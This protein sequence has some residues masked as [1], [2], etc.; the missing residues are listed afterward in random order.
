MFRAIQNHKL[1]TNFKY[2][3]YIAKPVENLELEDI[4]NKENKIFEKYNPNYKQPDIE[5]N[6]TDINN[7]TD[8]MNLMIN[9]FGLSDIKKRT[10]VKYSP[11]K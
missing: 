11:N 7:E 4:Y 9:K 10:S 8:K 3:G 2:K 5:I 6:N 1:G